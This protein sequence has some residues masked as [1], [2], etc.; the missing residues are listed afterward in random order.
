[1]NAEWEHEPAHQRVEAS[2]GI[3]SNSVSAA[4]WARPSLGLESCLP[5]G[6]S[7]AAAL[8]CAVARYAVTIPQRRNLL[9]TVAALARTGHLGEGVAATAAPTGPAWPDRLGRDLSRCHLSASQK[10]AKRS[11]RPC[12]AR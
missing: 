5:R 1:M 2:G 3:F 8:R 11:A 6:Y 7:L 10:G 12:G 9:A 4:R